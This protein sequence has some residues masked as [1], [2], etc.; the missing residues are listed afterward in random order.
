[1]QFVSGNKWF[2][3]SPN[4]YRRLIHDTG[5]GPVRAYAF[6]QPPNLSIEPLE[7]CHAESVEIFFLVEGECTAV[8]EGVE[9]PM[10]PSDT[11]IVDPGEY[12]YLVAGPDSFR[13]LCVVAPNLDD[14]KAKNSE[15]VVAAFDWE[16]PR[17]EEEFPA[18]PQR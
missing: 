13:M 1:V 16:I 6:S 4:G 2:T 9:V 3:S 8:V 7:H 10:K 5:D 12:H 17:E 15:D 18:W 14:A 11:L